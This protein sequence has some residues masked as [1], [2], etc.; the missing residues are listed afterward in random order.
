MGRRAWL[1]IAAAL[2]GLAVASAAEPAAKGQTRVFGEAHC[3]FTLPAPDWQWLDLDVKTEGVFQAFARSGDGG[4]TL[5]IG[6][7][8]VGEGAELDGAFIQGFEAGALKTSGDTKRGGRRTTFKGQ[9]CYQFE[10]TSSRTQ[11]TAAMRAFLAH[12]LGYHV[13]L[14]GGRDP[15]E[16]RP[17]F[18]AVLDG[19]AFTTPP[20]PPPPP[21]EHERAFE[22][23]RWLG[24]M[25]M[26][27]L[28][29][30]A[31]VLLV[32]RMCWPK[33]RGREAP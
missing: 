29:G 19:F 21:R 27:C 16:E 1:C 18:E 26:Y 25:A 5:V 11:R 10:T 31:L 17:D 7:A 20:A 24:R 28:A 32:V 15:V 6:A 23:G 8:P 2:T 22:A 14:V 12:G 13:G 9:P 30:A 33:R 3:Q 4:L